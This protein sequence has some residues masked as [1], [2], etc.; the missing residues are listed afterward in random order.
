MLLVLT[1][2][3]F[4][5]TTV[6]P[7]Y[8]AIPLFLSVFTPHRYPLVWSFTIVLSYQAYSNVDFREN[9]WILLLEYL[10][11]YGVFVWEIRRYGIGATPLID[12]N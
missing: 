11:V 9:P 3:L 5:A 12:E 1:V 6:H 8:L 10:V 2:Y 4:T 7:W